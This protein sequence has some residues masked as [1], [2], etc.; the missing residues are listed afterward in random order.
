MENLSGFN[1][2]NK[3]RE[4]KLYNY[5]RNSTNDNKNSSV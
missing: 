3:N 2:R 5:E 4:N 1:S